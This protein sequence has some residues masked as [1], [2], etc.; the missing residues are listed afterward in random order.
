MMTSSTVICL[1]MHSAAKEN[2]EGKHESQ[3]MTHIENGR[4]ETYGA[5]HIKENNANH[6]SPHTDNETSS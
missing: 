6:V 2:A 5:C 1:P 4:F 3:G